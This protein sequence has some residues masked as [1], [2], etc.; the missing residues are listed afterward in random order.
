MNSL[1]FKLMMLAMLILGSL[2]FVYFYGVSSMADE[3]VVRHQIIAE[4]IFDQMETQLA[5]FVGSEEQ[6][7]FNHYRYYYIPQ[8]QVRGSL[9]LCRSPLADVP[10]GGPI[11]SYFHV[12]PEGVLQSPHQP[13]SVQLAKELGEK[14]QTAEILQAVNVN[15]FVC[16]S[17]LDGFHEPAPENGDYSSL[18][19]QIESSVHILNNSIDFNQQQKSNVYLAAKGKKVAAYNSQGYQQVQ[20]QSLS[21]QSLSRFNSARNDQGNY[22]DQQIWDNAA[23]G[24]VQQRIQ[25][26]EK[27]AQPQ[28]DVEKQERDLAATTKDLSL[29]LQVDIDVGQMRGQPIDAQNM[30][31]FRDVQVADEKYRQ[32]AVIE[33]KTL[34]Q[35]LVK[36]IQITKRIR[37][38]V[39]MAWFEHDKIEQLYVHRLRQ[40]S[41]AYYHRMA[42]PFT[43]MGVSVEI[44]A[45]PFESVIT[46]SNLLWIV[47]AIFVTCVV[48]MYFVNRNCALVFHFAQRRQNFVSAVSHEL[49]TPLTAIRMHAE[50]LHEGMVTDD[51]M[52]QR[53]HKTIHAESERLSRLID[54]V[55]E[56]S[57]L[58]K[59]ERS[60]QL[61][62]GDPTQCIQDAVQMLQPHAQALGFV[63]E[64][65]MDESLPAVRFERDG[66]LQVMLNVIDNG[67]KFS[68]GSDDKRIVIEVIKKETSIAIAIRDF[69][70]G[71]P[72]EHA[73]HI[74]DAFY[75]G[76]RE[77][78]RATKGTGIGLAL[79]KRLLEEMGG[80]VTARNADV[81][82]ELSLYLT[83]T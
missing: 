26:I 45:L 74:F 19:N 21:T 47:I 41:F 14:Y 29:E 82:F 52:A 81:G 64:L 73:A 27:V 12:T 18:S 5:V 38:L 33:S 56:L 10:K 65:H 61:M 25:Q 68:A 23:N 59:N 53:Y 13:L 77:L 76:E 6:R 40:N 49:K 42:P 9:A 71:V 32:G 62:V 4:D 30:L 35:Q 37:P 80:K 69:G 28:V 22:V 7:P 11:K 34:Q 1:R 60:M 58:E 36:D 3:Q 46:P 17:I 63:I 16:G 83:T 24:A 57:R 51:E 72:A 43:H 48:A 79:V 15:K 31:L 67:L 2:A 39:H 44:E 75:R 20:Q 66:L 55:L 78:T 54:N 70:P 8:D 50:M